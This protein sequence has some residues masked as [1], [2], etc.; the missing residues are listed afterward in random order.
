MIS[1]WLTRFI[2]PC[3]L[4][5]GTPQVVGLCDVCADRLPGIGKHCP[6]CANSVADDHY[7]CGAC[8]RRPPAFSRLLVRWQFTTEVRHIILRGKYHADRCALRVLEDEACRL[9]RAQPVAVDA[10]VAMPVSAQRLRQRGFNQTLYPA[11]AA[12]QALGVPLIAEGVFAKAGRPPQSRLRTHAARRRNIR[13]AF[14]VRGELPQRLLLVD[15]VVTSGA[16]LHEAARILA[17]AEQAIYWAT[18]VLMISTVLQ[19]LVLRLRQ[20]PISKQHW[21]TASAI[22]VLGGVTL[23]LKNPMFIKWKPSIVYLVFA[24]VLLITQW[25]GK[26]NLIQK[27]LGSA[28]TMPDAL[29]RRLNTAWAVFFIFM[30]VLNLIIAYHFSDDFWVGFKLWGSAGGTLI[31]M[32]AQIYLLRGYLNHDDKP[33]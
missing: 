29:W 25:M 32:F 14:A 9:L 23:A 2:R 1:R 11:H 6:T 17:A 31:F 26:A 20:K 15:D 3:C 22:L 30:A 4:T 28:L 16:T 27:M 13:G 10:V 24:A 18:A 8:L 21:L 7:P 5:C 12:A 19:I 33:K